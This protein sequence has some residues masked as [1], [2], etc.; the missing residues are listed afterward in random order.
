MPTCPKEF[1][2]GALLLIILRTR[3]NENLHFEKAGPRLGVD[4]TN[5]PCDKMRKVKTNG[6]DSY[7][8]TFYCNWRWSES[9]RVSVDLKKVANDLYSKVFLSGIMVHNMTDSNQL[10]GICDKIVKLSRGGNKVYFTDQIIQEC[11]KTQSTLTVYFRV[12]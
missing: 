5:N 10:S 3:K 9:V 2:S 7:L 11:W 8:T 6:W 12:W 4:I 1:L